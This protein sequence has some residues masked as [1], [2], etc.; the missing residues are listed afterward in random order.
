MDEKV[1]YYDNSIISH[2]KYDKY[3][4]AYCFSTPGDKDTSLR[5]AIRKAIK[6]YTSQTTEEERIKRFKETYVS[7]DDTIKVNDLI[8]WQ[9]LLAGSCMS[10]PVEYAEQHKIENVE[11]PLKVALSNYPDADFVALI[12]SFYEGDQN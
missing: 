2:V 10:G 3:Y 12:K 5:H 1:Y 4:V 6:A 8:M 9:L 7:L 11:V